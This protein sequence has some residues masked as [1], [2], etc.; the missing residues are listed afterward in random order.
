MGITFYDVLHQVWARPHF[1]EISVPGGSASGR[2]RKAVSLRRKRQRNRFFANVKNGGIASWLVNP[3]WLNTERV[4]LFSIRNSRIYR[5]QGLSMKPW[6][7]GCEDSG[8]FAAIGDL[9]G[10]LGL[11]DWKYRLHWTP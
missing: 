9:L 6:K 7:A 10:P 11:L 2:K 4:R 1:V 5:I 3:A 8:T